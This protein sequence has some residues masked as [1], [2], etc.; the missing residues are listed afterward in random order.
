MTKRTTRG[1]TTRRPARRTT[2]PTTRRTAGTTRRALGVEERRWLFGVFLVVLAVITFLSLLSSQRGAITDVW[3][4]LLQRAFGWGRFFLPLFLAGIGLWLMLLGSEHALT[5][6][7]GRVLGVA[8]LLLC[9]MA[10][11]AHLTGSPELAH[12]RGGAIGLGTSR[13]L[14]AALGWSGGLVVLLTLIGIGLS[15]TFDVSFS[16]L[17]QDLASLAT[18]I[19]FWLRSLRWRRPRV[20]WL[21]RRPRLR[22]MRLPPDVL[23]PRRSSV[24]SPSPA[25]RTTVAQRRP[26]EAP[27]VGD[28]EA[29]FAPSLADGGRGWR[30][31]RLAD[32]LAEVEEQSMSLQDMRTKARIIE[33]TLSSLGVPVTVVEVNP[34]PVVTQFGLEPGY[35]ERRDRK[36]NV[37]RSKVKVSRIAALSNDLALALAAAPIRIETPVPGKGVVGLEVPNME[38]SIVGLRGVIESDEFRGLASPLAL[39][40][41]RDVSGGPVVDDLTSLPHLLIAGATGSGKS[42]CINALVACLLCH[43]SPEQ[44]KLLMVDPKR[45]EL[46]AYNGIPHLLAPVVVDP[47]RVVGVLNWLTRE[48][49]RRYKVFA[50]V[51]ARNI[52]AYNEAL[53][54]RG[55]SP[56]PYIVAF[57]DELADLMM[58]SPDEVERLICRIAQM[59]RAT[60]IHLVIATQ[61]PSVDVVTGLIKA[62]FPARLAF[63]VS[64]L[65]DSRVILDTPGAEKLLGHGDALYMAPDFPGLMRIQGCYVS[66]AE[67]NRLV[68]FWTGQRQSVAIRSPAAPSPQPAPPQV[69]ERPLVQRPLWPDMSA[70]PRASGPVD[71]QDPLLR[72]AARAVVEEQRASVSYLQRCLRIGYTRAARLIDILEQKGIIGPLRDETRARTVLIQSWEDL[73]SDLRPDDAGAGRTHSSGHSADGGSIA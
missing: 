51:G 37:R 46:S 63:A 57:I 47:E 45:V 1:R 35:T 31:P 41:G 8:I 65:V 58:V 7:W 32:I 26:A 28:A 2:R 34:G 43:N 15:A 53:S 39:G 18:R 12:A 11:S 64:S 30:L 66:D 69:A 38:A 9:G 5:L 60:G 67:I 25:P 14:I 10:L 71:D 29:P 52:Q 54:S 27:S 3:V 59:A 21:S 62:N 4:S 23:I 40:L 22:R 16:E 68:A 6:P 24:P 50:R 70:G 61:R 42:V 44:L 20:D 19:W 13:G 48:M 49:E 73:P 72:I 55:E 56:L 36:G 33:D 17:F